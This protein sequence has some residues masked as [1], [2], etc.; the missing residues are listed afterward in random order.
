MNGPQEFEGLAAIVTGGASGIGLATAA[1]L[2][3]RGARVACLDLKPDVAEP[4]A[5]F[6]ADVGDDDSVRVAVGR[7]VEFAAPWKRASPSAGS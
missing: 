1:L 3:E 4:L 7:A 6:H 5:G 2:T